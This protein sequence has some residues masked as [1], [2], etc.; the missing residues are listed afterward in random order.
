MFSMAGP[1]WLGISL[2][3]LGFLFW[4]IYHSAKKGV[5]T[6]Y[7]YALAVIFV[8]GLGNFTERIWHGYVCD[9]W[10]FSVG[11]L[12]QYAYNINDLII[13]T[14]LGWFLAIVG[15][16]LYSGSEARRG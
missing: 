1:F 10:G 5:I 4:Y 13:L 9:Y 7:S 15:N 3:V 12:G 11:I 2:I 16:S 14:G 8:G 6:I